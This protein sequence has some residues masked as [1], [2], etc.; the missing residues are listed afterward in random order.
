MI[1][2][3]HQPTNV[4][5]GLDGSSGMFGLRLARHAEPVWG[6]GLRM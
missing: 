2:Q 4:F 5:A 1:T 6:G 3:L